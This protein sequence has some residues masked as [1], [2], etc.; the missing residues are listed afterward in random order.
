NQNI[1][2]SDVL[3]IVMPG[4]SKKLSRVASVSLTDL[5]RGAVS[6]RGPAGSPRNVRKL[7]MMFWRQTALQPAREVWSESQLTSIIRMM[8]PAS[9]TRSVESHTA[10]TILSPI[11]AR[12][13]A[14][15]SPNSSPGPFGNTVLREFG[16]VVIPPRAV[17]LKVGAGTLV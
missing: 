10:A 3:E 4:R 1:G 5:N 6:A 12:M 13:F 14:P 17:R 15:E 16:V 2:S 8:R 7:S 11:V 9:P